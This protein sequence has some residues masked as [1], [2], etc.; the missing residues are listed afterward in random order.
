MRGWLRFSAV[1]VALAAS[2]FAHAASEMPHFDVDG[3]CREVAAMGGSMSQALLKACYE[4]EQASYDK[5][6][7]NWSELP[8]GTRDHCTQV[9][10]IG[11]KG[12]YS[13]L[14][15]CIDSERAAAADNKSFKFKR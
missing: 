15:A 9:A 5:T 12:S 4:G 11:G 10:A 14:E 1:A 3:H 13:L 6:K 2:G 7:V 8:A